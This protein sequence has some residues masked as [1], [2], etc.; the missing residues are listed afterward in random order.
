MCF[1]IQEFRFLSKR[2]TLTASLH[3]SVAMIGNIFAAEGM[4]NTV[5]SSLIGA[6]LSRFSGHTLIRALSLVLFL[7]IGLIPSCGH[8][9]QVVLLY[10]AIGGC[11]GLLGGASNTLITW[12]HSGRNVGPWISLV[13]A[14]FGLG[15]SAAPLLFV[16]IERH[17]GNGL[18]AFSAIGAFAAVPALGASLLASPPPP[19]RSKQSSL[20]VLQN[21]G[22]QSPSGRSVQG[23][24]SSA[25]CGV[26]VGSR[27]TYVRM[28]VLCPLMLVITLV[29]GAE[30]AFAG[31]IY[32]YATEHAGMLKTE[33]AVLNSLFW[34]AFT[35]GRLTTV[36]LAA[37]LTPAMLLIPTLA[38]EVV[39]VTLILVFNS[40]PTALWLGTV[41]AGIGVCALYSNVL[42]LLASYEL[43]TPHAVSLIGM[44]AALGHMSI[45]NLVSV[46]VHTGGMGFDALLYICVICDSIGLC[47]IIVV[48]LHLQRS[49]VPS[50]DSLIG[51]QRDRLNDLRL[52]VDIA[53]MGSKLPPHLLQQQQDEAPGTLSKH[54][55][56][57]VF[58]TELAS[59]P[60]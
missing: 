36:P 12:V 58:E 54:K 16:A 31:W 7:L 60:L 8:I 38:I 11:L 15:A 17:V 33:A 23:R 5:G 27:E 30:I 25:V 40:S 21:G 41:G 20:E 24:G 50:P 51:K 34:G 52:P 4:G 26:D 2:P 57:K 35:L 43:L 9:L 59:K 39:S 55:H 45:P 28:T 42:S 18:A 44:A 13:N 3:S 49:F 48:N 56:M 32:V 14:S 37:F 29:I 46:A 53:R 6:L 47:A 10:G 19:E 22:Q 1:C